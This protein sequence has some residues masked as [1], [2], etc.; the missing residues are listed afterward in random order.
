MNPDIESMEGAAVMMVCEK[1]KI[2]SIQIRAISNLVP[3]AIPAGMDPN[4][5]FVNNAGA[6]PF[7]NLDLV[8]EDA[9]REGGS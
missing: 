5:V 3:N 6:I 7:G 2:K 8:D 4:D 9:W 1:F